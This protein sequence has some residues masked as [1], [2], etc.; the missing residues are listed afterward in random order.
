MRLP[1]EKLGPWERFLDQ[2]TAPQRFLIALA[3][4][5]TGLGVVVGGFYAFVNL[6]GSS[7]SGGGC[8][9]GSGDW[10]GAAVLDDQ[11]IG[12]WEGRD[13]AE[14]YYGNTLTVTIR[15]IDIGS[16]SVDFVTTAGSAKCE[17]RKV[18]EGDSWNVAA[19][20]LRYRIKLLSINAAND[21]VKLE[22][23]CRAVKVDDALSSS[24]HADETKPVPP[25]TSLT[26]FLFPVRPERES[27]PF[28]CGVNFS[29]S[30]GDPVYAIADG[31]VLGIF[32]Y[33]GNQNLVV[34]IRHTTSHGSQFVAQY[35]A[36]RDPVDVGATVSAGEQVAEIGELT[37][38]S[39]HL[40]FSIRPGTEVIAS[41][42]STCPE[43]MPNESNGFVDPIDFLNV[44][45]PS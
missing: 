40:H 1:K 2:R 14:N 19:D 12:G 22:L 33:D 34:A 23:K 30:P 24:C 28:A 43:G 35:A 17:S 29:G 20:G 31:E 8:L 41:S 7:T 32:P 38:K 16:S 44:N 5:V 26:D 36:V 37:G 45:R 27:A 21:A 15:N 18:K 3:S 4:I 13:V 39:S 11:W 6:F 25:W 9:T 42:E 10:V